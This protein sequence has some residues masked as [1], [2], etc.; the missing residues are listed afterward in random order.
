MQAILGKSIGSDMMGDGRNE[1]LVIETNGD[2]ESVDVL[3][4]CGHG[5][6]KNNSNV[7]STSLDEALATPLAQL[8]NMSHINLPRKCLACPIN[9]VCGGG[10]LPHRYSSE[11]GFDNPTFYC[12]DFMKLITHIQNV[13]LSQFPPA[14]L[15]AEGISILRYEDAVAI[16]EAEYSDFEPSYLNEL[17]VHKQIQIR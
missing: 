11:N 16:T 12:N 2:I 9:D 8:Y 13:V 14:V 15:E 7:R 10:Y 4:I 6:T 1:V 17:L 5:F 3:K